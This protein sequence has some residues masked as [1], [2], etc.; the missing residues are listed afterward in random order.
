MFYSD[1]VFMAVDKYYVNNLP[2]SS[3]MVTLAAALQAMNV[4]AVG[5]KGIATTEKIS[6]LSNL[7]SCSVLIHKI[8]LVCPELNETKLV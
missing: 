2:S 4:T 5:D 1:T 8:Y 3:R 6:L 7:S